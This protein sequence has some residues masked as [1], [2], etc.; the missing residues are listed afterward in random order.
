MRQKHL[1]PGLSFSMT[2]GKNENRRR[3]HL[4]RRFV[5]AA[6]ALLPVLFDV[7]ND[8]PI[9]A[10]GPI[11]ILVFELA[12]IDPSDLDRF[13][14][15]IPGESVFLIGFDNFIQCLISLFR[16]LAAADG[17]K[18]FI[19]LFLTVFFLCYIFFTLFFLFLQYL[20]LFFSET[21]SLR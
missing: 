11:R 4:Y 21:M 17:G 5:C 18:K 2:A 12:F 19:R 15:L 9:I 1:Q 13:D 3:F 6:A 20:L 7:M 14:Q 8:I 16:N 10:A